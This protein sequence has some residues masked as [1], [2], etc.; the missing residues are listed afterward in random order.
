MDHYDIDLELAIACW[1]TGDDIPLD[2]EIRLLEQGYD[3][4]ALRE[5]HQP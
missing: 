3:V 2:H 1:E 4:A 5:Q